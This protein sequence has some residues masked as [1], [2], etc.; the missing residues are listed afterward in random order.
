MFCFTSDTLRYKISKL[1]DLQ[2]KIILILANS[3]IRLQYKLQ[4]GI[5]QHQLH[6]LIC[7]CHLN[8]RM[9]T[10]FSFSIFVAK[11][12]S[13]SRCFEVLVTNVTFSPVN[14]GFKLRDIKKV[15]IFLLLKTDWENQQY[16]SRLSFTNEEKKLLF[17]PSEF[18]VRSSRPA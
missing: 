11:I 8:L 9:F 1:S 3:E 12:S 15:L 18:A 6:T 17:I 10:T 14:E 2:T 16:K 13:S 7:R 5:T 4:N